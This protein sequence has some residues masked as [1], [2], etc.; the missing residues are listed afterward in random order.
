MKKSYLLFALLGVILILCFCIA[1]IQTQK[2][3]E[4]VNKEFNE[5]LKQADEHYKEN[6]IIINGEGRNNYY[7]TLELDNGNGKKMEEM[8]QN[9]YGE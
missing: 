7:G 1:V 2:R 5:A 6:P 9:E 3:G 8:I 4:E